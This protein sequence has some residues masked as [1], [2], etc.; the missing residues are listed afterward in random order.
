MHP[1]R[2]HE[3]IVLKF[4]N[5]FA[6]FGR[7]KFL[8]MYLEKSGQRKKIRQHY[9]V[10]GAAGHLGSTVIRH[11]LLKDD[12]KEQSEAQEM[13][14]IR[15]FGFLLKGTEP[16]IRDD[17]VRYFY[18]DITDLSTLKELFEHAFLKS[19]Q[20]D[21]EDFGNLSKER[22]EVFVI[23]SAAVI[24]IEDHISSTVY[25]V[26]V[27]GTKNILS[28]CRE[29]GVNRLVHVSSVHAIA[30]M[31]HGEKMTEATTFSPDLVIG[32]YAKSKA[33]AVNL[34]L[35]QVRQG[36]DAVIVFPSGIIG[37][38]DEGA[39]HMIQM[40][41]DFIR[42]KLKLCVRGGYDFVDV[43][44]VADGCISALHNGSRGEGY[45]LSG[46][47]VTIKR[48]LDLAAR[49]SD[50]NTILALPLFTAKMG[51]PFISL[52]SKWS[53][54][55]PLYTKYSLYTLSANSEFSNEKAKKALG[56]RIRKME[57]TVLDTVRWLRGN[58][59]FEK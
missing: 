18:G 33:M 38:Y 5:C 52:Y 47:Y 9:I 22:P 30:E 51:L 19:L 55:R 56:Y 41:S 27:N 35:D 43:R 48:L 2:D 54:K 7:E 29:Y 28:M 45:I 11:L 37:P 39:N 21:E 26:N 6:K 59:L 40:F 42:G 36:M 13:R 3:G 34:V 31:P 46:Q 50:R 25:D 17:R 16:L 4:G 20:E 32:G 57:D 10:T 53:K 58:H 23:H 14:E 12:E 44:D 15:V 8:Q 24:S 49:F 1:E